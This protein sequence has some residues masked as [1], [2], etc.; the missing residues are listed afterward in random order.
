VYSTPIV[1][2]LTGSDGAPVSGSNSVAG[3][4]LDFLTMGSPRY[5]HTIT[6][7]PLMYTLKAGF[8][9]VYTGGNK[10][11]RPTLTEIQERVSRLRKPRN[12]HP[13]GHLFDDVHE[14]VAIIAGLH[15][16]IKNRDKH[17]RTL[18]AQAKTRN[19][20]STDIIGTIQQS[21]L[22]DYY[23]KKELVQLITQTIKGA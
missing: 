19:R 17:L 16:D 5:Q 15:E 3:F 4:A 9:N 10:M 14:L 18:G 22:I 20:Q 13:P 12:Q 2:S 8:G 11:N 23:W 21:S 6:A 7:L 1:P